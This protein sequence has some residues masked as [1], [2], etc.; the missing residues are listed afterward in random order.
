MTL[1]IYDV[2]D[3]GEPLLALR[4]YIPVRERADGSGAPR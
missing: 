3:P 2:D 4:T 1:R